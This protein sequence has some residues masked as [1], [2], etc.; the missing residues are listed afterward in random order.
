MGTTIGVSDQCFLNAF[1]ALSRERGVQA[2][3]YAHQKQTWQTAPAN[4]TNSV[5]KYHRDSDEY[6]Q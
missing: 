6:L 1:F 4:N 5:L 2:T 3:L